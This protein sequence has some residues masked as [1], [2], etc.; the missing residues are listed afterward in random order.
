MAGAT[1]TGLNF[2]LQTDTTTEAANLAAAINRNNFATLG[3]GHVKVRATSAA[4]VVTVAASVNGTTNLNGSEG[5][6]ITLAQ[7]I[8]PASRFSWAG[9]TL[10]GGVGTGN[11]VAFNNLYA[12][13]GSVGGLCAQN[14]PSVYWSYFTG[15]GTAVTSIVLSGDGTKVAFA[16]NVAGVATLRILKWKAGEGTTPG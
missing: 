2:V 10:S 12:T 5:N 3:A 6:L 16:E 8:S 7:T 11:I 14:G 4:G 13:Q 15:T 1:N 9:A